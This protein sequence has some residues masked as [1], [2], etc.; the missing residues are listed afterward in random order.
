M[1]EIY[2]VS[3]VAEI[4][5]INKATCR[6]YIR[7]GKIKSFKVGNRIRVKQPDLLDFMKKQ[8][9]ETVKNEL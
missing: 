4:L 8:E 1:P 9:R 3:E 2:S 5:K 7:D 6:N